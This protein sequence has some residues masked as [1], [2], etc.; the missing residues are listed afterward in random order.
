M[1]GG[2]C[3]LKSIGLNVLMTRMRAASTERRTEKVG[4]LWPKM[5]TGGGEVGSMSGDNFQ[6]ACL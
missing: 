2:K 6:E 3:V 1:L 5:R 4:L